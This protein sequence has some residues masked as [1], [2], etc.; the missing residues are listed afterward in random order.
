MNKFLSLSDSQRKTVFEQ[1]A[2][3]KKLPVVAIEKDFW[4]TETLNLLFTL[5]YADKMV[6]KGGTS[7]SKVWGV[8]HR[9]SEDID[10]AVDRSLFGVEGDLTKKRLKQLR[11]DSSVF[12]RDILARDL[13]E[14]VIKNGM[15]VSYLLRQS[16]TERGMRHIQNLARYTSYTSPFCHQ[17]A[18][19]ILE[20]RCCWKWVPDLLLNRHQLL[21]Q[22]LS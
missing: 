16:Q 10:I 3:H 18:V 12:V 7:L 19:R 15:E 21:Q 22:V 14:A 17:K 1:T 8:I 9:F 5:P 13:S 20:T 2:T 4:V 11:K 6:F